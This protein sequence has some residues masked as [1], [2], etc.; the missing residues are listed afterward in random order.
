MVAT[1]LFLIYLSAVLFVRWR[2]YRQAPA[3]RAESA[4][5]DEDTFFCKVRPVTR[6]RWP[7]RRSR[8]RWVHDVL[9]IR[10]GRWLQRTVALPVR[11]PE[12]NPRPADCDGPS[13]LGLRPYTL[14]L[15]LDDGSLMEVAA[16]AADRVTM[17]GPFLAAAVDGHSSRGQKRPG[18]R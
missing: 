9:L 13:G 5:Q 7:I 16:A 1:L 14:Q 11:L 17:V 15:R 8:G 10:R 6:S 2:R 4:L 3:D 18:G 12:D